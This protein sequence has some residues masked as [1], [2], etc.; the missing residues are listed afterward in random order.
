M[1]SGTVDL[2]M[3]VWAVWL[4]SVLVPRYGAK[5]TTAAIAGVGFVPF[6]VGVLPLGAMTFISAVLGSMAGAWLFNRVREPM[7]A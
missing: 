6:S 2:L 1:W 4:Y 5:T 3:G 7:R